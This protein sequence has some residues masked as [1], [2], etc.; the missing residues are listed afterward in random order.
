MMSA[1]KTHS[2]RRARLHRSSAMCGRYAITLPPEAVRAYFAYRETPNFPP[3]YNIA[4]TQPIPVVT[5]EPRSA[6]AVRHFQLMR[7]GFLPGFVKDPK[8]FPLIINARA[9]TMAD[10]PSYGAALKRR[11]CLVIADG[12]YEWRKG[13]A[14]GGRREVSRPYLIRR[15]SGEPMGFAGLYETWCDPTG[16]EIDTACIITTSANALAALVHDRMPAILEPGAF[17]PWLDVEGVG[18]AKALALLKPA[19]DPALEIVEIGPA[20]NRFANDDESLQQPV[21][22]PIRASAGG[23]LI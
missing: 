3:R 1:R 5:A 15:V 22:A 21:A 18:A 16:G 11:R 19:P 6:G 23:L 4:P 12:F 8:S 10:K 20:V 7:W 13:P 17:V 14:S 9:E 2:A